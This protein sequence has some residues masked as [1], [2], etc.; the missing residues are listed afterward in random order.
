MGAIVVGPG[1][2]AAAAAASWE[3]A[4]MATLKATL[5]AKIFME[6]LILFGAHLNNPRDRRNWF[7]RLL[8]DALQN[9]IYQGWSSHGS[10]RS[11]VVGANLHAVPGRDGR[12][13]GH[14]RRG[15]CLGRTAI[16]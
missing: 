5:K 13:V 14:G 11:S 1:A 12:C 2:S 4:Q 7:N 16:R 8:S 15:G 6:T 3:A 10:F 9:Y